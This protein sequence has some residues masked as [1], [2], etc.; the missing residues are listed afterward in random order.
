MLPTAPAYGADCK[1]GPRRGRLHEPFAK[2]ATVTQGK[3]HMIDPKLQTV[4]KAVLVY[5]ADWKECGS[6]RNCLEACG[7]VATAWSSVEDASKALTA[8][9]WTMV[10]LF[11]RFDDDFDRFLKALRL[12][13]QHPEVILIANEEDGDPSARGLPPSTAVLSR[14]YTLSDLAELAEHLIGEA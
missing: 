10:V 3:G 9:A 5:G 11:T 7:Y 1:L 6:I 14:P 12:M 2:K 13:K 8:H 4:P